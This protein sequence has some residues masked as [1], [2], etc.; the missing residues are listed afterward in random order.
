MDG[1]RN[2]NCSEVRF[3]SKRHDGDLLSEVASDGSES[4]FEELVQ[5]HGSLVLNQSL[6]LLSNRQDAEDAAQAVFLVLWKKA[7]SLRKHPSVAAWLHRTTQNVC[8]NTQ[9]RLSVRKTKE[10]SAMHSNQPQ[11]SDHDQWNEIKLVLDDELDRLPEKYRLPLILFHLES[12]QLDEIAAITNANISTIGT[13]LR[14]GR[15]MLRERI[16]RRGIAV[17][18]GALLAAIGLHAGAAQLSASFVTA[19]V[20]SARL[21]AAGQILP[22][23][24]IS[25]QSIILAKGTLHML[26][27]AKFKV[28]AAVVAAVLV[29][30][31]VSGIM[32]SSV[33]HADAPP[34]NTE[35]AANQNPPEVN[36]ADSITLKTI[37][38]TLEKQRNQVK[39]LTIET[40]ANSARLAPVEVL[41]S[42]R[43]F[44]GWNFSKQEQDQDQM[45]NVSENVFAY[46]GG[47]RYLRIYNAMVKKSDDG[48]IIGVHRVIYNSQRASDGKHVWERRVNLEQGPAQVWELP[49]E[50]GQSWVQNPTYCR[51]FGWDCRIESFTEDELVLRK[52]RKYDFLTLLKDGVFTLDDGTTMLDG[53]EC[54]VLRGKHETDLVEYDPDKGENVMYKVPSTE[55]IWLDVDRGFAMLQ[56]DKQNER[57][58]L[59]RTTNSDFV[60]IL[61]GLWFPRKTKQQPYAPPD[62]PQEY[63]GRPIMSWHQDLVRWSVND[64]PDSRFDRI[65]K[66]G[67]HLI[68]RGK[69]IRVIGDDGQPID[70]TINQP[71]APRAKDKT[72]SK[73]TP[74]ALTAEQQRLVEALTKA[75]AAVKP[76]TAKLRVAIA[77]GKRCNPPRKFIDILEANSECQCTEVALKDI[78]KGQL[79][80]YHVLII[81]GGNAETQAKQ[82][83]EAG[84]RAVRKFVEAGGGYVGVCAGAK[85]ATTNFDWS[86][87]LVNAHTLS[88]KVQTPSP[89]GVM[90]VDMGKRGSGTVKIELTDAGRKIFAGRTGLIET[91]FHLGPVFLP[92]Q[93]TDLPRCLSLC[94]YRSEVWL[95]KLQIGTMVDSPNILAAQYGKGFVIIFGSHPEGREETEPLLVR[96]VKGTV[97]NHAGAD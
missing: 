45:E 48:K 8:R 20:H 33:L 19:T 26:A 97:R 41:S 42:L 35:M 6:R 75:S 69:P 62:A 38:A 50:P 1:D 16:I 83:G 25:N 29:L 3:L 63:Q 72:T 7:S 73:P 49:E 14:R 43:R 55:T 40:K 27:I 56:Y 96:A 78:G 44:G 17:E 84:R 70:Q 80:S 37:I 51:N 39:S 82:L 53:R 95:H 34:S 66:P 18:T 15:E 2:G 89:D 65:T 87:G 5:R 71:N 11:L 64:V 77:T 60:E 91:G 54:V 61:P 46:K 24:L 68:E 59:D 10:L 9:R 92:N 93:Q 21:F 74:K 31:G 88:N 57:W 28:G 47:K 52:H 36:Q 90:T 86:L 58:G 30:G 12:R 81:P 22:T 4:A 23:A 79:K 13:R 94:D 32:V 85:L 76:E 67:D